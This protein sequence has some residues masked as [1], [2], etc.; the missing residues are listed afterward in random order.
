MC[1]F[2][3]G[4]SGGGLTIILINVCCHL[5]SLV[6]QNLKTASSFHCVKLCASF[7]SLSPR[8]FDITPASLMFVLGSI[9][10]SLLLATLLHVLHGL[11]SVNDK[12]ALHFF[13][14][15]KR[16]CFKIF[17]FWCTR[18]LKERKSLKIVSIKTGYLL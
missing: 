16:V 14:F 10:G 9:A 7:S 17:L 18:S 4:G 5:H 1:V 3:G 8:S 12:R 13:F 11:S 6:G 15:N 2:F